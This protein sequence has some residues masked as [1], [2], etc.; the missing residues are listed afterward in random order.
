MAI[1]NCYLNF[2][3]NCREAFK[4]Y[5][6]VFVGKFIQ[7]N[8]FGEMPTEPGKEPLTPEQANQIMH[9]SLPIS[10]ETILM[11]SDVGGEWAE[12]F[13]QGTNIQLS[14]T[15]ESKEEA[16]RIFNGLSSGGN[17]TMPLADTF[18]GAYF[19]M[20]IDPFGIMWMVNYDY[21]KP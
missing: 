19:G 3:G 11:G 15:T 18:W 10:K 20:F 17:I 2:D 13:K 7:I 8:T 12:H 5:R 14:V 1:V 21:P 16:D 9:V 6:S 4:L